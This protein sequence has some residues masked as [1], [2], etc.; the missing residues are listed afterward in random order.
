MQRV[1]NGRDTH[2][3]QI[4]AHGWLKNWWSLHDACAKSLAA[5]LP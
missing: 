4:K 5:A 1:R 3:R 2:I